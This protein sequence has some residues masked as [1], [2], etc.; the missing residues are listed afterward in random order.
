[1]QIINGRQPA[2][3]PEVPEEVASAL[4]LWWH[5]DP[6]ERPSIQAIA[7]FLEHPYILSSQPDVA[8]LSSS[9]L[10]HHTPP[11]D[12]LSMLSNAFKQDRKFLGS[13]SRDFQNRGGYPDCPVHILFDE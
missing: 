5:K 1:M 8:Q 9:P 10:K 6:R 2:I 11:P 7:E 4:P 13:W 3:P 12:M